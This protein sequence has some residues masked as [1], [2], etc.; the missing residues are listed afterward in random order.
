MKVDIWNQLNFLKTLINNPL[1]GTV[2]SNIFDPFFFWS[3]YSTWGPFEQAKTSSQK[4]LDFAKISAEI[5]MWV[6]FADVVNNFADIVS[7]KLLTR[8]A[9]CLHRHWLCWHDVRLVIDYPDL[10]SDLSFIADKCPCTLYVV[11]TTV[12]IDYADVVGK[13]FFLSKIKLL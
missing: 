11:V 8:G 5:G 12:V 6:N 9:Q 1:K 7:E 4:C 10:L 2:W 13:F 3:K